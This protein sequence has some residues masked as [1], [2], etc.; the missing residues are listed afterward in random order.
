MKKG[1]IL[2]GA[3]IHCKSC[4]DVIESENEYII[5]GII[6]IKKKIG[7]KIY[8][9][10]IIGSDEDIPNLLQKYRY[11]HITIGHV[12]NAELRIQKFN[13]IKKLG[14]IFPVIKSPLAYISKHARV[15]EGSMIMHDALIDA[16]AH[17]GRNCIVNISTL[18]AHGAK[19]ED[20]CHV[21]ANC[22]LGDCQ[23]GSGTFIGC[24]C[25]INNGVTI[26]KN[27][28]IG[29]CSN[30]LKPLLKKGIYAG[31]PVRFLKET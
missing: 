23:I 26:M 4:I 27:S 31:N 6:D 17:V 30:V 9:Y 15:E 28:V 5:V 7:E 25:Y 20:H 18:I 13:Y 14:G 24:N 16:D 12:I 29:S 21:S 2:V 3:G 11:F 1:I 8:D 22:V 19:L 10:E